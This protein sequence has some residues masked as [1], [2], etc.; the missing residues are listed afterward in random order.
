MNSLLKNVKIDIINTIGGTVSKEFDK[1][2]DNFST[3]SE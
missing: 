3:N 2:L 1:L